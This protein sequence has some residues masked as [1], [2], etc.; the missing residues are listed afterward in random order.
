MVVAIAALSQVAF[1]A[2]GPLV[3]LTFP[4]L[5]WAALRFGPAAP[6]SRSR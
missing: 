1:H 4:G 2:A 5:L 6:P 3:Y